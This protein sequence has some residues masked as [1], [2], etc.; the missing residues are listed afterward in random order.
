MTRYREMVWPITERYPAFQSLHITDAV[1]ARQRMAGDSYWHRQNPATSTKCLPIH[2]RIGGR[3]RALGEAR[4]GEREDGS[5]AGAQLRRQILNEC[6]GLFS[7]VIQQRDLAL[8]V[9]R[10]AHGEH[11]GLNPHCFTQATD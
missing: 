4:L 5:I 1:A 10:T 11:L 6:N 7:T 9:W 8:S 3:A 2:W